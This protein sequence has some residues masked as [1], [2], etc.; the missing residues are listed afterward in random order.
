MADVEP[1]VVS[2]AVRHGREYVE[3][4]D[5]SQWT[6]KVDRKTGKPRSEWTAIEAPVAQETEPA[7]LYLCVVVQHQ[8]ENEPKHWSLFSYRPDDTGTARGQVWQ[9]KG[10]AEHMRH[11]HASDTDILNSASFAWPEST[12]L[13]GRR[14]HRVPQIGLL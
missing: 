2:H 5:G 10:D 3:Y 1:T 8:A 12:K 7:T 13:H 14:R 4:S 9:V 6:R 11:Q